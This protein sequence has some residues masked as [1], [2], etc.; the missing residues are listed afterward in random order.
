MSIIDDK[1]L[2]QIREPMQVFCGMTASL[3]TA[4]TIT[5]DSGTAFTDANISEALRNPWDVVEIATFDGGIPLDGSQVF[6]EEN[7]TASSTAG[8]YGVV[9]LPGNTVNLSFTASRNVPAIALHF[10]KGNGEIG[11]T[12]QG[13]KTAEIRESVTIP[14][15]ATSGTI[16]I[17]ATEK[18]ILDTMTAGALIQWSNDD[19]ISVK[20]DLRSNLNIINPSFEVSS[21]EIRAYYPQ[22]LSE[23]I[24]Q[25]GDGVPIWYYAGYPGD[26]SEERHFYLSQPAT[27]ESGVITLNADDAS[28]LLEDF[29]IDLQGL[30]TTQRNGKRSLYRWM[31]KQIEDAGINVSYE[32]EPGLDTGTAD[33]TAIVFLQS[34]LRDHIAKIMCYSRGSDWY[35]RYVDAGVPR[36][37][38][39]TPTA[40]WQINEAD[41]GNVERRVDRVI[42]KLTTDSEY[43]LESLVVYE[44][45]YQRIERLEVKADKRKTLNFSDSWYWAYRINHVKQWIWKTLDSIQW[46]PA[47]SEEVS[48]YGKEAT[49]NRTR[50]NVTPQ[51]YG[52]AKRTGYKQKAEIETV[53]AI[54]GAD[55]AIMPNWAFTFSRSEK[56]GKFRWKGDPR[57]QPRD[58]FI[59]RRL[60]GSTVYCT[61]ESIELTHE[62]GGTYAD[63]SYREGVI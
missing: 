48:V 24:A 15:D 9:I 50:R 35:P 60:N 17:T 16:S 45:D 5:L 13:S 46:I 25:F 29:T 56:G 19:L 52:L 3:S 38:W 54:D 1:N 20:L 11:Y 63:I 47:I 4:L 21:I 55:G 43:G 8:K 42:N 44:D 10:Y 18:T 14:V 23:V 34:S 41:C 27:Q 49:W 7:H 57:M 40:R 6:Y 39:S 28:Y 26:Y 31:I 61:I 33:K 36:V 12:Y 37:Q 22:D 62:K 32:S 51:D 59:F 58:V 2:A 30:E 53:G